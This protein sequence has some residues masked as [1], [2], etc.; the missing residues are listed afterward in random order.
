MLCWWIWNL[1][2]SWDR[3]FIIFSLVL[4]TRENIKNPVSL[5]MYFKVINVMSEFIFVFGDGVSPD[6]MTGNWITACSAWCE[7]S[8]IGGGGDTSITLMISKHKY[9]VIELYTCHNLCTVFCNAWFNDFWAITSQIYFLWVTP[10]HLNFSTNRKMCTWKMKW[11]L[12]HFAEWVRKLNEQK[13]RI[14]H[15]PYSFLSVGAFNKIITKEWKYLEA[16]SP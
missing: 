13:V 8:V 9:Y 10:D 6:K 4:R 12:F 5:S 16:R 3:I 7:V 14:K 15:F 11:F 2:H 1:F